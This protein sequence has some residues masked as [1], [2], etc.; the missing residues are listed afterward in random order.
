MAKR[1]PTRSVNK[2]TLLVMG[3]GEHDKAFLSHMKGIYHQRRSGSKVTL[4]FS[5]GGSPHDI[6]KDMLKKSRH[7]G[8]DQKFILMD[9]DV[10]VKQQDINAA[11]NSGI[12]ILYSKPLCL[13]GM[14]LSILAQ[15]IPETAQKCK[16]ALH[17]QLSDNPA[18]SKSYEPL[19]AKPVLDDTNHSTIVEIRSLLNNKQKNSR[20]TFK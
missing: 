4:D 19:L 17:P 13:E 16:S 3:E 1:K 12:R 20:I 6:I 18:L 9:S 7:V 15:S 14:L 2:T 10:P 5:S 8:Y 11:N